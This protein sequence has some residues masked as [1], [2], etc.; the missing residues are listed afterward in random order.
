MLAKPPADVGHRELVTRP[1]TNNAITQLLVA[2]GVLVEVK[3]GRE[4]LV[5]WS[6][7]PMHPAIEVPVRGR[8]EIGRH[9]YLVDRRPRATRNPCRVDR[10]AENLG[11]V[12]EGGLFGDR[13]F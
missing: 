12:V 9:S 13:Y 2:T 3:R 6:L 5:N 7:F 4:L 11:R 10:G 8:V 1:E